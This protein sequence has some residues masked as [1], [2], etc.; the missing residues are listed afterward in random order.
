[1]IKTIMAYCGGI[2]MMVGTIMNVIGED[3]VFPMLGA[4]YCAVVVTWPEK[5]A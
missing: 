4:I 3:P 1:M 2:L 5:G